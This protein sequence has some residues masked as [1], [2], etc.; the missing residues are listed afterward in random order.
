MHD[1]KSARAGFGLA[2]ARTGNTDVKLDDWRMQRGADGR[3]RARLGSA[4]FTLDLT[5]APT[6]APMLQGEHGYS[7][8]GPRPEQA[9]YYYSEP[10]LQVSGNV[11]RDGK[12][13]AVTGDAWLDHEWSSQRAGRRCQRLGLGRHQPR[14]RRR[15]DGIP[16][17]RQERC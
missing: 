6:Q 8:K 10:Q 9:S 16:D 4:D 11:I 12:P 2:Y 3:Y 5:L 14:R 15:L 7:R 17:P 1:Q 13:V